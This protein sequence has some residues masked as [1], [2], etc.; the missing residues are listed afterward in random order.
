MKIYSCISESYK[1]LVEDTNK[2]KIAP[3]LPAILQFYSGYK[4]DTVKAP[5]VSERGIIDDEDGISAPEG[6]ISAIVRGKLVTKSSVASQTVYDPALGTLQDSFRSEHDMRTAVALSSLTFQDQEFTLMQDTLTY[7][8]N[9]YRDDEPSETIVN[10][11]NEIREDINLLKGV[12]RYTVYKP[13]SV[14][15]LLTLP[16]DTSYLSV[17]SY[18]YN[19]EYREGNSEEARKL[20][21]K[22]KKKQMKKAVMSKKATSYNVECWDENCGLISS[23][24]EIPMDEFKLAKTIIADLPADEALMY[25]LK[26]LK[27]RGDPMA[28]LPD[29]HKIPKL[30][31]WYDKRLSVNK[32]SRVKAIEKSQCLTDNFH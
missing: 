32:S 2:E 9:D 18:L 17:E 1:C 12:E 28:A 31:A 22:R 24:E 29:V 16:S 26:Y 4:E 23:D 10:L 8:Y 6:H 21:A 15:S 27:D 13:K 19:D 11:M 3:R 7:G 30:L 14:E 25:A 5:I 20:K